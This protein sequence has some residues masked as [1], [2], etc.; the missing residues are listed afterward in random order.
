MF[1]APHSG[2]RGALLGIALLGIALPMA[3]GTSTTHAVVGFSLDG[4][5]ARLRPSKKPVIEAAFP[6][7]SYRPGAAARLVI[8]SRT[9]RHVSVQVFRAGTETRPMKPR[10]EMYGT[11]VTDTKHLGTVRKAQAI[12]LRIPDAA[13][14][15]YFAK[16]TGSGIGSAMRRSSFDRAVWVR[17]ASRS[18]CRPSR[19][20]RT[21]STTT[22]A[23]GRRTPGTPTLR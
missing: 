3:I 22:T 7:Q 16:L 21:T 2:S 6:R 13:S 9:A 10:D 20:R 12:A 15:V 11:P 8:F 18:S 4:A 17:T 1:K 5:D 14:G 23:T 19:G